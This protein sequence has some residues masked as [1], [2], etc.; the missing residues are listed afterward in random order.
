[1]LD[2]ASY[3]DQINMTKNRLEFCKVAWWLLPLS[4]LVTK[5]LHRVTLI[6]SDLLWTGHILGF[7]MHP[8]HA[9]NPTNFIEKNSHRWT[10]T[11]EHDQNF[12]PTNIN[13]WTWPKYGWIWPKLNIFGQVQRLMFVGLNF[14]V[15][16][17]IFI[18]IHLVILNRSC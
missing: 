2:E 11:L 14:S 4:L 3:F 13:R 5:D 7:G 8:L 15:M 16:F 6:Q 17:K 10:L 1:M 12:T 18:H 9:P